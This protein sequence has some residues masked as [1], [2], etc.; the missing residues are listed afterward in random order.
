[1]IAAG[2]ESRVYPKNMTVFG[3]GAHEAAHIVEDWLIEKF[4]S[5]HT[6]Y[7]PIPRRLVREAYQNARSAVEGKGKSL[8]AL[9][10]EIADYANKNPSECL[11]SGVS[12]YMTNGTDAKILSRMIWQRIKEELIKVL[13]PGTLKMAKF[14]IEEREKYGV[15]DED[16]WLIGVKEDAPAEFKEAWSADR[17]LEAEMWEQGID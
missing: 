7:R 10:K 9:T 15:F 11:A 8:E 13:A 16:G 3:A 5:I 14:T 4:R 17:K 6:E 2:V 12:D 1:M